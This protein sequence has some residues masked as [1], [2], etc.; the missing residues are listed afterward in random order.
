MTNIRIAVAEDAPAIYDLLCLMHQE[1]GIFSISH[2]KVKSKITEVLNYGVVI[3]AVKDDQV[4]GTLGLSPNQVWYTDDWNL[5]DVWVFV[6]PDHRR[7]TFAR[8]LLRA[9]KEVAARLNMP[10][11][12]GVVSKK[13]TEGKVRLFSRHFQP[14]GQFFIG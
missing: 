6:H 12:V 2:E 9:A 10:I 7:S 14:I 5:S 11:M 3:V 8:D 4:V 1:N 13:E